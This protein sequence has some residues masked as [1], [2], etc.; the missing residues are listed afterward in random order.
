MAT[1]ALAAVRGAPGATDDPLARAVD[2]A[3]RDGSDPYRVA[4]ELFARLTEH[5]TKEGT[6]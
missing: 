6:G 3:L 4:D 2:D 5:D 1:R